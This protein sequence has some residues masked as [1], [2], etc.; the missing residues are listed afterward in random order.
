MMGLRVRSS[1]LVALT[2]CAGAINAQVTTVTITAPASECSQS[3]SSTDTTYIPT[4]T[5]TGTYPSPTK[6]LN[7]YAVEAGKL[8]FGTASDI[9]PVDDQGAELYD[10]GYMSLLNDTRMFG[11]R[12]PANIQKVCTSQISITHI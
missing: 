6:E 1:V 9:P 2:V 5:G 8:Y 4:G 11:Q 10:E 12:T 7:E 3:S